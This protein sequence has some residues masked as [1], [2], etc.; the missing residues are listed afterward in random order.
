MV[1]YRLYTKRGEAYVPMPNGAMLCI[2]NRE[3]IYNKTP[4]EICEMVYQ[5]VC[6]MKYRAISSSQGAILH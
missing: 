6:L 3:D 1:S 2:G 4:T 5:A